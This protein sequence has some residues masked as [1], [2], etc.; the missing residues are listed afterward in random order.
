[1]LSLDCW[2]DW[3]PSGLVWVQV[4][5]AFKAWPRM[6][7]HG[8]NL[9]SPWALQLHHMCGCTRRHVTY[10]FRPLCGGC[11]YQISEVSALNSHGRYGFCGGRNLEYLA[12]WPAG[13]AHRHKVCVAY[14]EDQM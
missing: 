6:E 7:K 12:L 11:T 9:L 8:E 4:G 5:V 3:I 10:T 14:P 2:V 1:M 13:G